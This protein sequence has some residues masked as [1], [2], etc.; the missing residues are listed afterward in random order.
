MSY[1]TWEPFEPGG[2]ALP[3]LG[4]RGGKELQTDVAKTEPFVRLPADPALPCWL[5]A[6]FIVTRIRQPGT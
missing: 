2:T 3:L 1:P 5:I 4:Y 6:L